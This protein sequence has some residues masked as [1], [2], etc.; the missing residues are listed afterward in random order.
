MRRALV[1]AVLAV[2]ATTLGGCGGSVA[3]SGAAPTLLATTA[4]TAAPSVAA[5]LTNPPPTLIPGCLPQCWQGRLTRPGA[6]SGVYTTKYFFGG[7]LTLTVPD[8]WVSAEDSTGEFAIGRPNDETARLDFWIDVFAAKNMGGAKDD[9]VAQTG[10]AIAAWFIDKPIIDVIKQAPTTL[11]D[12]A[13][14]SIE[15]ER[16]DKA[17]TEDPDCPSALQPCSVAFSYPEWDGVFA[18]GEHFHSRLIYANASWGGQLHTIYAEFWA[19]DPS[20]GELIDTVD[21]VLA[22]LQLPEGVVAAP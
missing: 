22:S 17:A 2:L 8:G 15:Y 16:N 7:Q 20:Y 6:I 4:P 19:A 10:D 18:E 14:Q 21:A 13:A 1:V 9:T 3:T 11:G 5:V 12:I